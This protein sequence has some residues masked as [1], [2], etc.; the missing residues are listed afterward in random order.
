MRLLDLSL[1][2]FHLGKEYRIQCPISGAFDTL[3]RMCGHLITYQTEK[4]FESNVK[5]QADPRQIRDVC[6][7]IT[8]FIC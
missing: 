4:N 1:S 8:I 5:L 7:S 3:L 2:F 6:N